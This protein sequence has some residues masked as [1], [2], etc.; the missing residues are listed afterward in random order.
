M[1]Y[2]ANTATPDQALGQTLDQTGD[3]AA[4]AE[5]R[6]LAQALQLA[7]AQGWTWVMTRT[8]GAAA[9]F[10]LGETELLLPGGPRDLA[11]L[12]SRACDAAALASLAAIDP[13]SLRVRE[14][15]RAG[16][17]ART[18]AAMASEAATRRWVGFL[19]LPG[20]AALGLRLVWESADAIWVWA[21]DTAT[22]ENH[23]SK[24]ALLAGILAATLLVR[25]SQGEAAAA[26]TLDRRIEAVMAFERFKGRL[27]KLQLGAWTAGAVGRIR[28][29]LRG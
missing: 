3:W 19:A 25:L 5:A 29:G 11:A 4:D 15:I 18:D 27:G 13:R 22:D 20:N 17:M 8:A 6:V 26:A 21:G 12:H 1:S 2:P 10:S 23:Y 24:R 7:P 14:R 28:Y 16:A 9:G